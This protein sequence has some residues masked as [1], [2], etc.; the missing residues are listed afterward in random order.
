MTSF[1]SIGSSDMREKPSSPK[2]QKKLVFP[3]K[4]NAD[5]ISH[6]RAVLLMDNYKVTDYIST[7]FI[8]IVTTI[9][10]VIMLIVMVQHGSKGLSHGRMH[11]NESAYWDS[12]FPDLFKGLQNQGNLIEQTSSC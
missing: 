6:T 11:S 4:E 2:K 7:Y 1:P 12:K 3:L 8:L 9:I 5:R 10:N